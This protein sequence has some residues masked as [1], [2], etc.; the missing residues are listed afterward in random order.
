MEKTQMPVAREEKILV[1]V[2]LRPLNEKEI[3]ANEAADW[4]CINDTT[5]LYRNTLREGS[6]FPSAYSFDRVYRGECPTRQIYEDG[7]KEIAL[8]VVKGI[9]CSIFAYGQTSS[10]KTY[11]MSGITEF[12]VS[13]KSNQC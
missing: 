1:L 13:L 2:R 7:T 10:G 9:N 3:A 4:E 8:S 5:I 6:N 11:T 12:A